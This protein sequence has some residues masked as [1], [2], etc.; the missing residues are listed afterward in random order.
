MIVESLMSNDNERRP[1]RDIELHISTP[2][3]PFHGTFLKTAKV[4]AVIAAV[5]EAKGLDESDS[6]QLQHDKQTLE[7]DRTLVSYHLGEKARLRLLARGTG[8]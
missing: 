6:F 1:D 2:A 7:P 3:G 4:S 5:V 8:V